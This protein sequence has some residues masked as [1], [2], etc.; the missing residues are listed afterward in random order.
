MLFV[1]C[2]CC[3]IEVCI[4]L[5]HY[6]MLIPFI[7]MW[8]FLLV[9]VRQ[10]KKILSWLLKLTTRMLMLDIGYP[11]YI[12][13]TISALVQIK[14]CK[15]TYFTAFWFYYYIITLL[16]YTRISVFTLIVLWQKYYNLHEFPLNWLTFVYPCSY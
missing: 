13:N 6:V 11:K 10:Q 9:V 16:L 3:I 2:M 4:Q 15:I 12:W 14:L 1:N 8:L 5:Y 7:D